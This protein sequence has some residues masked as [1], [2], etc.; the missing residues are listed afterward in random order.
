MKTRPKRNDLSSSYYRLT[1]G[2]KDLLFIQAQAERRS[3]AA[4]MEQAVKEYLERQMS[5]DADLKARVTALVN[6]QLSGRVDQEN[7]F[8]EERG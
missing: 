3:M 7:A 2:V 5:S 6:Q 1:V 8:A 4:V